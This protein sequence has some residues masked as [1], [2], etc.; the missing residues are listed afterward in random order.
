MRLLIAGAKTKFFHLKEFGDALERLGID[1]KLVHDV[2][3]YDGLPSRNISHW[4]QSTAKFDSLIKEFKPDAVFVDRQRHFSLAVIKKKIPLFMLLRGEYWTEIKWAKETLYKSPHRRLALW[5]WQRIAEKCF[6]GS[7]EIIPICKYLETVVKEH[8]PNKPTHVLHGGIDAS[9]WYPVSG[10]ELKHPC[11]GLLQGAWI[12]G[13]TKEMLTLT[14][15]LEAMPNVMFYW[16]GD[17]PYRDN[18]LETLKKYDN[19]KWLGSLEYP[20]KV[21]EYLAAIDVYALASGID[22][23]PLTL[24]EAAL[25]E[26]P[27]VAT[28]VGGIPELMDNNNTGFLVEKGDHKGW[29]EKLSI[30]INDNKKA[31]QMGTAGRDFVKENF[32]WDKIAKKFITILNST[33]QKS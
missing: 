29:I 2:D 5:Q 11:V 1:Y 15:V 8:Y 10:M 27:V 20:D 26:K 6:S 7:T 9:R 17:G 13:K 23:S 3:V 4:F 30:L 18:V 12:W 14:K 19:F 28:N 16:V 24:Q 31:K 32:G 33:L 25:M 21:R 22:M